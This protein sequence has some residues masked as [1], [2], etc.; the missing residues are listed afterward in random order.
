MLLNYDISKIAQIIKGEFLNKHDGTA[1]VKNIFIDSRTLSNFESSLFFAIAGKRHNGHNYLIELY[2]KGIRNF[3]VSEKPANINLM[4]EAN[5]LF[6]KNTL[7]AIQQLASSHR[8]NFNIPVIAI[9]GSNGKTVIKEWLFQLLSEDKKIIRSPK[10]YNSQVGVPLSVWQMSKEHELA[11][12]E[13]GISEPDEMEKLQA[14]ISP[15]IGI[16]TN[17]GQAHGENFINIEQK[18][19]EKLRLF[20]KVK[21]LFYCTDSF[22][23][24]EK[25]IKSEMIE[26]IDVFSWSRNSDA[27]LKINNVS[28]NKQKTTIDAVFKNKNISIEIPFVDDAS[29]ENAIHCWAVMLYFGCDNEKIK[30]RMLSLAPVAMR[31]ELKEGINNCAVINDSYNSDINS[32]IIALD[33]LNQQE[34]HK[35]KTLILSDILQSGIDENDLYNDIAELVSQKGVTKIIGI[36]SAI[37]RHSKKFGKIENKFYNTT[38]DFLNEYSGALFSNEAILLKGARLFKFEQIGKIIQQKAHETVLEINLNAIVNNLNYFRSL[39]NPSTKMMAM[40][41]AFSYGSGSYEIAN[42]LQFHRV[43][44]LAVAYSD[45]GVELRNA[46]ITTPILVMNPQEQSFDTMIRHGLEP[47]IY[48]FRVLEMLINTVKKTYKSIQKQ[49]DIHIKLDTGMHR[50]GFGNDEVNDLLKIIKENKFINLKSVFSHLSS[51]DEPEHDDFTRQQIKTFKEAGDKI[52]SEFNHDILL[53]ILNTSGIIRFPEAQFDMVRLGIGLYG[54]SPTAE[55]QDFLQN[56]STLKSNIS[57]IREIAANESVG[58]GRKAVANKK[59]KIA[60]VPIGYADGLARALGNGKGKIFINGKLA[61]IVG[62]ICMD[63]T[64]VDVSGIDVKEGDDVV[65]FGKDY[66]IANVANDM[67]TIPYEVFTSLS[68]RIKRIYYQE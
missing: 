30:K 47:E 34:Q 64:M 48:S 45:E 29:V 10:S 8:K 67:D 22:G 60:V 14:I 32:L 2:E 44:Y 33:F 65:I 55:H 49:I 43:D 19:G 31:L 21:T 24:K 18:I 11:I 20:Q 7:T 57:Q 40:V 38:D 42:I 6:V 16:F 4:P 58:Y 15:T 25:I 37:S 36:G 46:G 17:I 50:L 59:I 5:I 56:V 61:P 9:T 63:M 35:K 66:P 13:A 62:N 68:R 3:V 53:H 52:K 54:I 41:K 51:G 12:F 1:L 23:I 39:L 27:T 28:K 26:N